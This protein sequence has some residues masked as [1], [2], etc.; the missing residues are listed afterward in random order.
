VIE[1]ISPS[2]AWVGEYLEVVEHL[3]PMKKL[4]RISAKVPRKD[5]SQNQLCHGQITRYARYKGTF[6]IMLYT[7]FISVDR[8][9]P[10][11][12]L[13]LKEYSKIDTLSFLAHELAH[14]V[15]WDHSPDHKKLEAEITYLFMM[16]LKASGYVSEEEEGEKSW[17]QGCRK[18]MRW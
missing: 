12:H 6:K 5:F 13:S 1:Y 14:M 7:S 15:H 16:K 3:V 9:H 8:I 2:L 11:V 4:R 17:V 18:G 10:E